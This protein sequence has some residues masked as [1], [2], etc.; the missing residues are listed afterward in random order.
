MCFVGQGV[1]LTSSVVAV[2]L[3]SKPGSAG[4]LPPCPGNEIPA[5][6]E[7]PAGSCWTLYCEPLVMDFSNPTSSLVQM[8]LSELLLAAALPLVP[9]AARLAVYLVAL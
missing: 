2:K 1:T 3:R 4:A 7:M 8:V 6:S 9:V 5:G